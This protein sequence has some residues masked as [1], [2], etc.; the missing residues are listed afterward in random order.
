[1]ECLKDILK[2][3]DNC[4]ADYKGKFV[5]DFIEVNNTI[6]ANLA[7]DNELTGKQYGQNLINSAIENVLSDLYTSTGNLV[8]TNS[9]E[10]LHYDGRFVGSTPISN[11]GVIIRDVSSSE[12]TVIQLESLRIKPLFDGDFTIVVDNGIESKEFDFVAENGIET[13]FQIDYSTN[14]KVVKIFAK[15]TTLKFAQSTLNK[16]TC[17]GCS[18]KKFNLTAQGLLN[19]QPKADAPTLIPSAYLTCDASFII[20]TL[21]KNPL[22]KQVFLKA[23]SLSVGASLFDRLSLSNRL[24]DTTLNINSE[25]VALYHNT[26]VAKYQ[27]TMFGDKKNNVTSFTNMVKSNLKLSKDICVNC[28][29]IISSSTAVF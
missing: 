6:L 1:M 7:N 19:M 20:C 18:G 15:D 23:V 29:S 26:L 8:F 12:L 11:S 24:N 3:R 16:T 17:S 27:E 22:I 5:N 4:D 2:F 13:T 14:K 28:N 25:A 21:L 9:I 10:K